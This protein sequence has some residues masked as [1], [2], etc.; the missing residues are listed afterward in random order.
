[1]KASIAVLPGDGIG[2]EV[3]TQ[4]VR[5]LLAVGERHDHQFTIT[6]A[7]IGGVAIDRTGDAL[8]PATKALVEAA[9]AVVLGAVGGPKW[10]DPNAPTRPEDGLLA[11]RKL[12]GTFANLRPV[13]PH[14]ALRAQSP[15]KSELLHDVDILF[16]RELTGGAYFGNKT[17]VVDSD[18]VWQSASDDCVYT[19]AEV[20]RVVR[21]AASLARERR[22]KLTSVDKA[23]VM[24]SSRLWRAVT[25]A[26]MASEFP[27]VAVEHILVDAFA[28]HL[29]RAPASFDVVVTEN[30]FGDI[31]TDEAAVLA[32][33]IGVLPSASL[34]AMRDDGR[35]PGLYEPIHGTAPDIAGKGIANPAGAIL[36]MALML[37]YTLGLDHAATELEAAV[38]GAIRAGARTADC[39]DAEH[40]AVS[41]SQ[42]GDAVIAHLS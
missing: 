31:L 10:S 23:N 5:A 2:P 20:T 22:G 37:R 34:G 25:S 32:G 41:T 18:G 4:A 26:V 6:E 40:P 8:P 17:K 16:V 19:A 39:A 7:L 12:L 27:D 1:M 28:M 24:A 38:H 42:F 13:A 29:L 30:L 21:T 15:L 14:P 33:S 9:D 36:S 3:T 35:V 11:L